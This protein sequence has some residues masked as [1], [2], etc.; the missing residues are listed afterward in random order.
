LNVAVREWKDEVVFLH[1]IVPGGAD[2][3]YGIHVAKLA[4]VPNEVIGRAEDLLAA[5]E[6]DP[7]KENDAKALRRAPAKRRSE[8]QLTL[9]EAAPNPIVEE[10]RELRLDAMTPLEALAWLHERQKKVCEES[11]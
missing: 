5:F 3:S 1:K 11:L 4:G 9:F 8:V 6:S 7:R 2:R 10:L